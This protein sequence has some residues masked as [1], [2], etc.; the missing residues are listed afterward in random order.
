MLITKEQIVEL[1]PCLAGW[2]WYLKNQ[3][4]DLLKLLI[5]VNSDETAIDE[6]RN[7]QGASWAMWLFTKLMTS[8]QC[9]EIAIYAAKEVLS[10]YE[11][12]NENDNRPRF[13]I[14]IAKKYIANPNRGNADVVFT[15]A[16]AAYTAAEAAFI[17]AEAAYAAAYAAYTAA[18]TSYTIW[19]GDRATQ[20]TTHAVH[21]ICAIADKKQLQEKIIRK[22]V[23]ILESSL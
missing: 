16:E 20:A 18:Y 8:Q 3:E 12:Y 7:F 9:V 21:T 14:E 5:K 19:V 1:D 22:A 13:A 4:S 6:N 23:K 17:A 11:I 2:G 10:I 15:A